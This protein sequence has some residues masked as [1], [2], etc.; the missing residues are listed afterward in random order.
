M[1][2]PG[3][4]SLLLG[5]VTPER[6]VSVADCSDHMGQDVSVVHWPRSVVAW[7]GGVGRWMDVATGVVLGWM[8]IPAL[9]PRVVAPVLL[10]VDPE[11]VVRVPPDIEISALKRWWIRLRIER[12]L[13]AGLALAAHDRHGYKLG[14]SL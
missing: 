3:S 8:A 12:G 9:V 10:I 4:E 1:R 14:C 7:G 6:F 5:C 11:V 2:S 13:Q